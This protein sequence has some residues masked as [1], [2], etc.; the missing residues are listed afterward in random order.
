MAEERWTFIFI[1]SLEKRN[2]V[3]QKKKQVEKLN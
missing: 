3:Y 1:V 2:F